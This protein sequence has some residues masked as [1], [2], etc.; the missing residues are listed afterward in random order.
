MKLCYNLLAAA[1]F[2]HRKEIAAVMSTI[3]ET[4]RLKDEIVA[5]GRQVYEE[6]LKSHLEPQHDGSFVA[7]E[8]ESGRYFLG[9]TG[10]EALVTAHR[11]M[12]Q[13]RFYLKRVGFDYTHKLGGYGIGRR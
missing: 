9:S 2:A 8:P 7:I 6:R 13:S 4:S 12:P 5:R 3:Q 10:T 1:Y 11:E